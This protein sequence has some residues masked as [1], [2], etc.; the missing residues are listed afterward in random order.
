MSLYARPVKKS[1]VTSNDII[2][3][4]NFINAI[5]MQRKTNEGKATP[6]NSV[7]STEMSLLG[8]EIPLSPWI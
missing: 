3:D 2:I 4:T 6:I 5:L 7:V 1:I 8:G